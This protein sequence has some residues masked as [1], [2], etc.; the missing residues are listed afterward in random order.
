[1][2]VDALSSLSP[3]SLDA[4]LPAVSASSPAVQTAETDAASLP[5][6]EALPSQGQ[7]GTS[8]DEAEAARLRAKRE[9]QM[10]FLRVY[11]ETYGAPEEKD[12]I[13]EED[14]EKG[15]EDDEKKRL[16]RAAKRSQV[17]EDPDEPGGMKVVVWQKGRDG[18]YHVSRVHEFDDGRGD[19]DK[20][21]AGRAGKAGKAGN[22]EEPPGS[23]VS[24]TV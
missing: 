20:E 16:I 23:R 17:I 13:E 15:D 1:M 3:L 18:T 7:S 21:A 19:D 11:I 9:E 6:A 24:R 14:P 12:R 22:E 5:F 2:V 10:S 8:E 4:A